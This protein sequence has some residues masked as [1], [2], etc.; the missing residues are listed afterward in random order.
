MC[1]EVV[2]YTSHKPNAIRTG[3]W[4][5]LRLE[6]EVRWDVKNLASLEMSLLLDACVIELPFL[7]APKS[8]N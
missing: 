3:S 4:Q 6:E 8:G 5:P 7:Y 2:F 1:L